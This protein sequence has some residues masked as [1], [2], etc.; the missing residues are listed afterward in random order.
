MF[1]RFF[2]LLFS[3]DS[4]QPRCANEISKICPRPREAR[5]VEAGRVNKHKVATDSCISSKKKLIL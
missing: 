1:L 4:L 3:E 5:L 2:T